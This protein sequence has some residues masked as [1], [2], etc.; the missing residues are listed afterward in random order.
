M[1][2]HRPVSEVS[3]EDAIVVS[4]VAVGEVDE[5]LSRHD[6]RAYAD[7]IKEFGERG[8]DTVPALKHVV[9]SIKAA[10]AAAASGG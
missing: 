9:R 3:T 5:V 2:G 7:R 6:R 1:R 4:L 8:G 10:R